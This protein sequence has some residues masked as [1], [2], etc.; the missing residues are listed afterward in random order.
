MPEFIQG[1]RHSG[2]KSV[3]AGDS[4]AARL[5]PA[6]MIGVN[7]ARLLLSLMTGLSA[8]L[9]AFSV[10]YVRGDAVG[11]VHFLT[12]R[13]GFKRLLA[14]GAS[15][16][17]IGSARLHLQQ[18]AEQLA[19]PNLATQLIPLEVLIG[20][21][22]AYAVWWVFGRRAG[23]MAQGRERQDVQERMVTRFAHR[24]GGRFTLRDLSEQSPLTGE[25]AHLTVSAMLESG[26]LRREGDGYALP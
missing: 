14:S 20:L 16:E 18:V 7:A 21:L 10:V 15:Q 5:A 2:V 8:A 25:Q 11:V 9:L 26:A 24:H 19:A 6:S 3:R 1:L 13:A 17:Q 23:R 4:V 22:S 12:L